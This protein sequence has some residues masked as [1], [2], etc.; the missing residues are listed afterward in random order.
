MNITEADIIRVPCSTTIKARKGASKDKHCAKLAD[1]FDH[2][3]T[4]V[5]RC[6]QTSLNNS[7]TTH[8]LTQHFKRGTPIPLGSQPTRTSHPQHLEI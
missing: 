2:I 1:K 4:V 3:I 7:H 5:R 8:S 6:P